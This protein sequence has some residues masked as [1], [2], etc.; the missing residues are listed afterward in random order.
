MRDQAD[1]FKAAVGPAVSQIGDAWLLDDHRLYC[2]SAL[3]ATAYD[4]ILGSEKAAAAFADPPYNV[5]VDGHVCG[6]GAIKHREF[7]MASGE[8]SEDEFTSFLSVTFEFVGSRSA[9]GAVF[10]ARMDW[11]HIGE[12]LAAGRANVLQIPA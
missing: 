11:R 1:E 10:Y 3:D 6:G 9:G 12:I 8:M 5:K 7:A 4:A 2:G